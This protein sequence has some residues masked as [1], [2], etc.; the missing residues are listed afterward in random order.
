[1][2]TGNMK[3]ALNG[4][5]TI[6]TDDGANVEI[7]K[8][9]GDENFFLF[10]LLEPEVEALYASGYTPASYYESDPQL[11]AAIDL[12][13][14]GAF[15]DGDRMVFAPVV[16]NLLGEDRFLTLADYRSYIDTQAV[17]DNAY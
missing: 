5:L 12:I 6:G 16:S 2:G 14:S 13:A 9:V 1:S 7:R 15:S 17:V 4:A 3:L 8:L 11:R 10:G